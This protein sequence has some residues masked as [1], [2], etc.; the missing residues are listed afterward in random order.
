[1]S[2]GISGNIFMYLCM[3]PILGFVLF[4][5]CKFVLH[6]TPDVLCVGRCA[7]PA[8]LLSHVLGLPEDWLSRLSGTIQW[9]VS[10]RVKQPQGPLGC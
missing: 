8:T 3:M 9:Y 4:C 6:Y 5:T 2:D 7:V 1:M 10:V